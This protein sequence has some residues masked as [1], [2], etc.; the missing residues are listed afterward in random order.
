VNAD[1]HPAVASLPATNGHSNGS[2]PDWRSLERC[3]A[4]QVALAKFAQTALSATDAEPLIEEAKAIVQDLVPTGRGA[5]ALESVPGPDEVAFVAAIAAMVA[6]AT[7]KLQAVE[8]NRHAAM[9]DPLT[10]LANRSLILDHLA[11]ALAR[12]ERRPT[13]AAV[14]FIDLDDFKGINDNLGHVA[15]DELLVRVGE[16][17][18]HAVRPADTLGRWGGDEF[19]VVCEDLERDSDAP[20]IVERI[21]DAFEH[22]FEVH[23]LALH[24]SASIGVAV[25][26]HAG[27][28]P[29]SLIHAADAD[30]YRVKRD[31][32][33]R[34]AG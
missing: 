9:H 23:H 2:D 24:I 30:M 6:T 7:G 22:P 32:A 17:L 28:G 31:Q 4:Q 20:G 33:T 21:A 1:G 19:V 11:L 13:L 15:G 12:A 8:A 3:L 14:I 25:S 26:G 16:R 18:S 27:D 10:G 29:D 5:G 34:R